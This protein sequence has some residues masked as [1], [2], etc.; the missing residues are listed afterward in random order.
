MIYIVDV[1]GTI[2]DSDQLDF[3]HAVPCFERIEEINE[4]YEQG[5][6]I[7]Y[8]ATRPKKEWKDVTHSQ[9]SAWG[10]KYD[11]VIFGRHLPTEVPVIHIS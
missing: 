4:L 9:L 8:W 10:C 1:D 5:H 2:C 3:K 6:T 11:V 7:I